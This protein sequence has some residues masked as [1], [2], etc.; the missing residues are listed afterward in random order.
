MM[1]IAAKIIGYIGTGVLF[2]SYQMPRKKQIV[3]LQILSISIFTVHFFLLGGYT[4][5][6]MNLIALTK[7][8][9]YY[10]E[11]RPWFKNVLF[12]CV[13]AAVI[14][15]AGILTWQGF[16]SLFPLL[17]MLVHTLAYNVKKEKWFRICMFPT[18]PLW[19]VYAILTGS[20]PALIG[21]ILTTTSLLSAIIRYD[22]LQKPDTR[23]AGD[24]DNADSCGKD[25][26]QTDGGV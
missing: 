22:I 9:L 10:F 19:M 26:E 5:A 11:N 8:V 7:T 25:G 6:I 14:L 2:L 20:I 12:T 18:S 1:E 16:P 24:G 15:V 17:A 21:E 4:G 3:L 13:Y 23:R